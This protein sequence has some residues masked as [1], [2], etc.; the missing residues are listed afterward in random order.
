MANELVTISDIRA[1][2]HCVKGAK[3][4]FEYHELDF[5]AFLRE[6]IEAEIL[7]ATND[8]FAIDVVNRKRARG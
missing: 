8:Q 7:L 4:W 6:G 3:S 2:G 1:A 5:K